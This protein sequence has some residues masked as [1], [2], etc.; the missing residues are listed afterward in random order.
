MNELI[1]T[2]LEVAR[3]DKNLTHRP[4]VPSALSAGAHTVTIAEI[5]NEI[6]RMDPTADRA[7]TMTITVGAEGSTQ[8][9]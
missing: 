6:L 2:K 9:N 3:L 7:F 8:F 1:L 4:T 5:R